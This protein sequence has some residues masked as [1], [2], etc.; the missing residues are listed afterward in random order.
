MLVYSCPSLI[1]A[2][3]LYFMCESPKFLFTKGRES[4]AMEALRKIHRLNN[5]GA[6]TELD[7]SDLR[8]FNSTTPSLLIA[9][10]S[11]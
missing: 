1:A 7:V 8:V 6:K 3:W 9:T 2:S 10:G 11:I 5:L 4:E